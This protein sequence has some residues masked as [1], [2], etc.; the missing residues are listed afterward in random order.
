M[1]EHLLRAPELALTEL[2]TITD[3][4][5]IPQLNRKQYCLCLVPITRGSV[6]MNVFVDQV[7]LPLRDSEVFPEKRLPQG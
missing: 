2:R 5:G 3:V 7:C 6:V 1:V 4:I